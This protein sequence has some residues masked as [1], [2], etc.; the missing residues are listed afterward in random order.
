MA[1]QADSNRR[2]ARIRERPD[3]PCARPADLWSAIAE[4]S[5]EQLH[6]IIDIAHLSPKVTT[7]MASFRARILGVF[8]NVPGFEAT[9]PSA[10]ILH[11]LW[12]KYRTT[13][14]SL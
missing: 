13:L 1:L 8:A 9:P 7:D 6:T 10:S 4:L 11:A 14:S 5:G 2:L 12:D 3:P